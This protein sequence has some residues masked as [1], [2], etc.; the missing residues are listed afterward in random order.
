MA[1]RGARRPSQLDPIADVFGWQLD[2][3]TTVEID[4]IVS[5][6][7]TDPVEPHFM[8]PPVHHAN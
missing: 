6:T 5:A 8:A 1:L 4:R 7:V 2:D 3:A